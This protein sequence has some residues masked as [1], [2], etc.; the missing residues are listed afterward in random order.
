MKSLYA[1]TCNICYKPY[2]KDA[3]IARWTGSWVHRECRDRAADNIRSTGRVTALP[4]GP[5]VR[6]TQLIKPKATRRRG[7]HK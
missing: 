6:S 1:G 2:Y 5:V 4:D 7:F 3:Y